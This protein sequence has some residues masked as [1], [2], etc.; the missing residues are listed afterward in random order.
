VGV[1]DA[2]NWGNEPYFLKT[3]VDLNQSGSFQELEVVKFYSVP[4]AQHAQQ[5]KTSSSIPA[6]TYAERDAIENPY[7]GMMILNLNTG[8]LNY[9][10]NNRWYEPDGTINSFYSCGDPLIDYRDGQKYQT[11]QI[12]DQC[13][14]AENLNVGIRIDG[15]ENQSNNGVIEK[16]CYDN[17][18]A[19]CDIYGGLYQ[20]DEMMQYV[21]EEGVQ[22]ICP[23]AGGW[24]LPTDAEWCTL[25]QTVDPTITCSSTDWRGI[26]GGGKLKEA[27]TNHWG[28][29]NTD[30]T[31]S[32]GFTALPG[33]Y[34]QVDK[35]FYNITGGSFLWSSSDFATT[36]SWR[37]TL[38]HNSSQVYRSNDVPKVL[39][40]SVRCLKN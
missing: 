21:T 26:D 16:Y 3:A 2:I 12:G 35:T 22:G 34:R 31:N 30:A 36:N 10:F 4:Y 33:G 17:T 5:A 25:E 13:W 11:V 8:K 39:G 15:I 32:S 27:G 14:M 28:A 9:F 1:F 38:G 24:H 7:E 37:R 18:E 23:P 6:M 29:P 19:N 20:W 40:F